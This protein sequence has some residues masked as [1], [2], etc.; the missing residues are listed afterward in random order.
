MKKP[1]KFSEKIYHR[2]RYPK[3]IYSTLADKYLV[4]EYV[5]NTIGD[6]YLIPL[7]KY[8]DNLSQEILD[9]LPDSFVIKATHGAGFV[10]IV[11]NKHDEDFSSLIAE[12]NSWL[13]KDFSRVADELH[14]KSIKPRLV[15]EKAM[16]DNGIPPA[17][18]KIHV[19]RKSES[20]K[21]Y[22]F[23]QVIGGRFDEVQQDFFLEDWTPAPFKR[24][25][26]KQ[27]SDA[28]LISKPE[29]IDE[30]IDISKKLSEPFEYA[31]VDL[32]IYR[33]SPYFGE[34]TFTPF[35]GNYKFE[36]K[37]WD[38]TLGEKFG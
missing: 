11:K 35:C 38:A 37:S 2:M 22:I 1:K 17:D 32:Y 21:P 12:V 29:C 34:I 15:I 19:F 16:L 9:D 25:G 3:K 18:Y 30:L 20:S 28:G 7:Y 31:R 23:F 13:T 36:P 14:Y 8:C 6:K 10:R 27:L 26:A 5:S 33:G 4:R 24:K